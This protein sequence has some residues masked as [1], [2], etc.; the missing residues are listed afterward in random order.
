[1]TI[2]KKI[3]ELNDYAMKRKNAMRDLYDILF[4]KETEILKININTI[5]LLY[6]ISKEIFV[7]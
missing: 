2:I 1:M 5:W 6:H 4:F 7:Y 3:S